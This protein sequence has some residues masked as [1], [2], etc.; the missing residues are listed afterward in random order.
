MTLGKSASVEAFL[1]KAAVER[2]FEVI[3]AECAPFC[4][5]SIIFYVGVCSEFFML[6]PD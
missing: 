5:V 2:K 6:V 3:V 4:R 1:K